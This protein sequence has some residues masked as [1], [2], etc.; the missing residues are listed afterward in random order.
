MRS[1]A[2]E[3]CLGLTNQIR[4]AGLDNELA[5]AIFSLKSNAANERLAL[6][7]IHDPVYCVRFL[8]RPSSSVLTLTRMV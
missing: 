3:P 1:A 6:H 2:E 8:V 5:N 4:T 7:L